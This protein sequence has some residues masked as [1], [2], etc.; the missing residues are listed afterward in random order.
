MFKTSDEAA[1]VL[2]GLVQPAS[3]AGPV[4]QVDVRQKQ[5]AGLDLVAVEGVKHQQCVC[6]DRIS[7]ALT[8]IEYL[9]RVHTRHQSLQDRLAEAQSREIQQL[10]KHEERNHDQIKQLLL[11]QMDRDR[12]NETKRR[13]TGDTEGVCA[14]RNTL[15]EEQLDVQSKKLTTL[16]ELW[17]NGEQ[18]RSGLVKICNEQKDEISTLRTKLDE[19]TAQIHRQAD[20]YTQLKKMLDEYI[21]PEPM[22]DH[23]AD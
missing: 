2:G 20:Q 12:D 6:Q 4:E 22:V 5:T 13:T 9:E 3:T 19:Q 15:V 1:R 16:K 8:K 21:C 14:R 10:H 17:T 11:S 18:E 23:A 7:L